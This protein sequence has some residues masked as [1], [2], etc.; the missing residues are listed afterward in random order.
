[1]NKTL[2]LV[3]LLT[4]WAM[5]SLAA[6]QEIMPSIKVLPWNAHRAAISMTFDD[7]DPSHLDVA[8]PELNSRGLKGTFFLIGN[9]IDR[10]DDWRKIL[11]AGHE[12]G[13][14]S[15]DHLHVSDL[16]TSRDLDAQVVGAQNVLQ[17]EFGVSV[18]TYG[19]PYTEMTP[20]LKT[21]VGQS[22]LLAR[23]G[24]GQGQQDLKSD[25]EP[26]W[27]NL[28]SKMTETNLSWETYQSWIDNDLKDEAWLIL[29]IHG[30]E[31]TP[32]GYQPISKKIFT[33]LLDYLQSKDIWVDTLLRVGAYFRAQKIFE[34]AVVEKMDQGFRF[35]W[36]VPGTFPPGVMLRIKM[37]PT[38]LK[39]ENFIPSQNGKR[40]KIDSEGMGTLEFNQGALEL[41]SLPK[42]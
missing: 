16:K 36:K 26:D 27:L 33:Q 12:I 4:A 14:H 24:Y 10:K 9:K 5:S 21:L 7:G 2:K 39:D 15:L 3:F 38:G 35:R 37:E 19:Y 41:L 29:T 11:A 40:L 1:M 31:G 42:S 30:L 34:K 8:L 18:Y 28:P 32:W 23:G 13:N 22:H 17:K 20:E 6:A 25:S